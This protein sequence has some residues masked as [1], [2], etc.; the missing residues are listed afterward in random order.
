M[1]KGRE[2]VSFE[3]LIIKTTELLKVLKMDQDARQ[4]F[5]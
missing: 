2:N 3:N 1:S 4:W 5:S